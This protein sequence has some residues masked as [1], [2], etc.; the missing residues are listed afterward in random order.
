MSAAAAIAIINAL[1]SLAPEIP[2]LITAAQTVIGALNEN[3]ALTA[4]EQKAVDAGLDAAHAALQS[5]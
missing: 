5:A 1:L 4:D 2:A 3:R